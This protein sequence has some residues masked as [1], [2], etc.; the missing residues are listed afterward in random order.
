MN[1]HNFY[2]PFE[3]AANDGLTWFENNHSI[4]LTALVVVLMFPCYLL[5]VVVGIML[6]I[7][8]RTP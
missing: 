6:R 2:I 3:D 7:S 4:I 1:L 5:T 8:K